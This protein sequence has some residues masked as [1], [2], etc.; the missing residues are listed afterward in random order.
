MKHPL[1]IESEN[2]PKNPFSNPIPFAAVGLCIVGGFFLYQSMKAKEPAATVAKAAIEEV[3][4][5]ADNSNSAEAEA[6]TEEVVV[7]A[8]AEE[9]PKEEMKQ[10]NAT[11]ASPAPPPEPVLPDIPEYAQYLLV[12]AGSATFAAFRAIKARDP[13]AKILIVGEENEIPYMRPPLSKDLWFNDN[14]EEVESMTFKQYN[15]K[16]RSIYY[17]KKEFYTDPKI[18]NTLE[19]GGVAHLSGKKVVKI[20]ASKKKAF[21]HSGEVISYDK[22]LLATG[23]KPKNLDI[24]KNADEDVKKRT[25]LFRNAQ[26]FR[27]LEALAQ[28]GK[29][30]AIVGG[31][32]LGSELACALGKRSIDTGMT[33]YQIMPENGNMG[34]VLPDYLSKWTTKKIEKEGV[35]VMTNTRVSAATFDAETEKIVLETLEGD[36]LSV[37]TI[38]AAVGLE[39][40]TEMAR[41]SGLE[42]D[43]VNGGF[44]VNA[45]LMARQDLYVAGDCA[46]FYDVKLGRRRVEHHDH[47]VVSGRLA[48]ENMAGS[49]KPYWHQS[50]F[51]SDLGPDV[52]YE[53]IGICDA[54]LPTTAV[55]AK[56]TEQD[57]PQAVVDS[58]GEAMRS[59]TES[60]PLEKIKMQLFGDES[61]KKVLPPKRAGEPVA[62][63]APA[64]SPVAQTSEDYGKGIVFY[65]KEKTVVG[66][67]LW[68]CF[69]RMSLARQVLK[70][71]AKGEDLYEVAK[72][73]DIYDSH[74]DDL[75]AEI[76]KKE[77]ALKEQKAAPEEVPKAA[78]SAA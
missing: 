22:C 26:D 31:G 36:K 62:A 75:E 76:E 63:P 41:P 71:G 61:I 19:N 37:D 43:P 39:A 66:I 33:V 78:T 35:K 27:S 72:M 48:G 1:E 56:K 15:G 53:A 57:S 12:G 10:G 54:S 49:S 2:K 5:S 45:E 9:A 51:W 13:K 47:A 40:N 21:L 7:A 58:T 32:F 29:T 65:T 17:E 30:V 52:G 14:K 46:C 16:K 11:D 28:P 24:L 59:E 70:D 69:N 74:L 64:P 3:D 42:V 68:N 6:A 73:F 44:L 18:L 77:A 60:E 67:L 34:K 4:E 55:F 38:V 25:L 20:D 23:G 50:M 8:A